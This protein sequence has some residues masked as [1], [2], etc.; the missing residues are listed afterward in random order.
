MARTKTQWLALLFQPN[1]AA[2]AAGGHSGT[3][4][5]HQPRF[6]VCGSMK[7]HLCVRV[8]V[9]LAGEQG[10]NTAGLRQP[11]CPSARLI[12]QER[13]SRPRSLRL[14]AEPG[15]HASPYHMAQALSFLFPVSREENKSKSPLNA[16]HFFLSSLPLFLLSLFSSVCGRQEIEAGGEKQRRPS[17]MRADN[18]N[19]P[20]L[21]LIGRHGRQWP[22]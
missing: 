8:F 20:F 10:V 16:R 4:S 21:S 7:T 14:G 12:M 3:Q 22:G 13:R 5:S 1:H 9:H 15:P 2:P 11:S 19:S 6:L 17:P 18:N